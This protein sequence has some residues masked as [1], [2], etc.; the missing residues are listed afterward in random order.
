MKTW[1]K[2][3]LRKFCKRFSVIYVNPSKNKTLIEPGQ[4]EDGAG[5]KF[6]T[7]VYCWLG[8]MGRNWEGGKGGGRGQE[9]TALWTGSEDNW[10]GGQIGWGEKE[11]KKWRRTRDE[12][13]QQ[14]MVGASTDYLLSLQIIWYSL[15]KLMSM[16]NKPNM[17]YNC[18]HLL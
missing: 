10:R 3:E 6:C 12:T 1:V 8:Q 15:H 14:R 7:T 9:T 18:W 13:G 17:Q 16:T 4:T 2:R 5:K 11:K